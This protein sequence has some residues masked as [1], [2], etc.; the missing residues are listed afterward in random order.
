MRS[1]TRPASVFPAL[2]DRPRVSPAPNI[3]YHEYIILQHIY[4]LRG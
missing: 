1:N 3:K 4:M 2:V